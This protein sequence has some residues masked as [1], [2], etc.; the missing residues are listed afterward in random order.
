MHGGIVA[1]GPGLLRKG[2][3]GDTFNTA[4]YLRAALPE[5]WAVDY[6]TA[7][8]DD[9]LSDELA[10]FAEKAGIGTHLIRRI[11]GKTPGLYLIS[12]R[13]DGERTFSYWRDTSAAKLLADDADHLRAAMEDADLIYF[14]GITLAILSAVA[15]DTL[16]S[17]TRRARAS[18]KLVAFDP[19]IRPRLWADK[20]YAR[21]DQR[22]RPRRQYRPASFDDEHA[23][24]GDQNVSDT[25]TRYLSLGADRV[26]VKNGAQGATIGEGSETV[27]I[28]SVR[29][30]RLWIRQALATA[31]TAASWPSFDG[32][33]NGRSRSPWRSR[34]L[35]R[36]RPS[37]RA[38][39]TGTAAGVI[40]IVRY[41]CERNLRP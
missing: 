14:S 6:F 41:Q 33:F 32:Q 23:H 11:P 15:A 1:G 7:L 10:G 38:D 16:L 34:R 29:P 17:E 25:I 13:E 28:P 5:D 22:R 30:E 39:R 20:A 3:A 27:F 12:L 18:G 21:N 9:P 36:H 35:R 19:N 31:S 26:V 37:R 2:F 4:W 40:T 24:F 8:G